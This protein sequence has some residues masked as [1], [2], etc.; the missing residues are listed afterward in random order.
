MLEYPVWMWHWARPGDADVPWD[1]VA[2]VPLERA[3][4]ARKQH[5]ASVF[6]TQL[7]AYE[8]GVE[9]GLPPFVV[10]RLIAVGEVVFR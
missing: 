4:V 2:A 7:H 1:R 10:Q 6:E 5:A 9:P 8:P 3:A